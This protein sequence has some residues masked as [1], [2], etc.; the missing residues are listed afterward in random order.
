VKNLLRI[1]AVFVATFFAVSL[2]A[3]ASFQTGHA[4]SAQAAPAAETKAE[5]QKPGQALVEESKE[6]ATGKEE[7]S[8]DQEEVLK[9]SAM[10]RKFARWTGLENHPLLAYWVFTIL[11][12][13]LLLAALRKLVP[14]LMRY[15]EIPFAHQRRERVRA[16]LEDARKASD[17]ANRRLGD[18]E[19]KLS[20]L[21]VDIAAIRAEAEA[22]N[23][24]EEARMQASI[25]E[26]RRKIV[27]SSQQEIEAAAAQ[28][29][30]ELKVYAA[31]LAISLAEKKINVDEAT[32]KALVR[33]FT[34]Q[35]NSG[36][37]GR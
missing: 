23:K 8:E 18:I 2:Q 10:V 17:E 1:L 27:L 13:A 6:A 16:G 19:N 37:D 26:E 5:G 14:F 28:A 11:N 20:R 3:K 32:D 31:D 12:F 35:I 7:N 29:R 4:E 25:E 33:S 24:A 34:E 36:K 22:V 30:R 9:H 21:D 15:F